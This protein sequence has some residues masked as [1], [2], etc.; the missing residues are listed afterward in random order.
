MKKIVIC[1]ITMFCFLFTNLYPL[2]ANA[3][4]IP[5][6]IEQCPFYEFDE[7]F[8]SEQA[9]LK[10]NNDRYIFFK[11][12]KWDG[13]Y[14]DKYSFFLS[15]TESDYSKYVYAE[16]NN[17]QFSVTFSDPSHN[18]GN[19]FWYHH[20]YP[21]SGNKFDH[22]HDLFCHNF[23]DYNVTLTFHKVVFDFSTN[24]FQ[25]YDTSLNP[26]NFNVFSNEFIDYRTNFDEYNSS[27]F[28]LSFE[29][30]PELN[31]NVD[32]SYERD[33]ITY[34]SDSFIMGVTNHTN[35]NYIYNF[36]ITEGDNVVYQFLS[37]EWK[38][39][40]D[41]KDTEHYRDALFSSKLQYVGSDWHLV[42]AN[43]S[44][45]QRFKWSQLNIKANTLYTVE[46]YSYPVN[47]DHV[48]RLQLRSYLDEPGQ[49]PEH[50]D[51]VVL[52]FTSTFSVN[53]LGD[54]VYDY[55]DNSNGIIP[56]KD[57][58]DY[59]KA[60]LSRLATKDKETG[61]VD[62]TDYSAYDDPDSWYN[63][64]TF[65]KNQ[66]RINEIFDDVKAGNRTFSDSSFSSGGSFS[67]GSVNFN[68]FSSTFSGFFSFV[69]G[70]FGYLPSHFLTI[71]YI[72]IISLVIIGIIRKVF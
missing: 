39:D 64:D 27:D 62:Y 32:R 25:F 24:T 38:N 51:D 31:G 70:I 43:T 54:V 47:T 63:N 61:E 55:N 42:L 52:S 49:I 16:M 35:Q 48:P 41:I 33:G 30:A 68:S 53:Y 6:L 11:S 58:E 2:I 45:V 56:Y 18:E 29:F 37:Y 65:R 20:N 1:T 50:T 67:A 44:I 34:Y 69:T 26:L 40:F 59:Y 7:V 19:F 3:A 13:R 36:C 12:S 71:I 21:L 14:L 46:C 5:D 17:S 8:Q 66:D 4:S 28:G 15:L 9:R 72:G 23:P 60:R 10:R 22:Y 57:S